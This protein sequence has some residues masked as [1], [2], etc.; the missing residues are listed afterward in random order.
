MRK[1]AAN[2][3]EP[4]SAPA[5]PIPVLETITRVL[6]RENRPMHAREI[7]SSAEELLGKPLLWKSVKGILF[8]YAQGE[9]PRFLRVS[10]GL[11]KLT[12]EHRC[13]LQT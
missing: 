2:P 6:E 7:H 8:N 13:D 5:R 10:R 11:Y 3:M 1:A 9:T 12:A 4:R